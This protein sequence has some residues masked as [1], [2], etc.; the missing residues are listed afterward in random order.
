[1][2]TTIQMD[3]AVQL[4]QIGQD[5]LVCC[6]GV[7]EAAL[8]WQPPQ[9]GLS[10]MFS[11]TLQVIDIID[12][13]VLVPIGGRHLAN[14]QENPPRTFAELKCCYKQW[15]QQVHHILDVLPP[16]IL[17]MYSNQPFLKEEQADFSPVTVCYCLLVS[18][19]QSAAILGRIDTLS[20]LFCGGDR[21]I[22]EL[23][24]KTREEEGA[25]YTKQ[26]L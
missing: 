18:L 4:E 25:S 6:E 10:A 11:L 15:M 17:D 1:M 26:V 14:F 19:K 13:C 20:Q 23:T 22:S 7:P 8:Y 12:N 5:I 16:T 21:I 3:L 9:T 2:N 24:Q